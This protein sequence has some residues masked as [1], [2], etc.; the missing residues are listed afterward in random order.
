MKRTSRQ[1]MWQGSPVIFRRAVQFSQ[2]EF[3]DGGIFQDDGNES[4]R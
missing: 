3:N 4:L 1:D 2:V